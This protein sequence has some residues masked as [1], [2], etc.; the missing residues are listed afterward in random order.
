MKYGETWGTPAHALFAAMVDK[1]CNGMQS[2][3]RGIIRIGK[4]AAT[5]G[6]PSLSGIRPQI[7]LLL[8]PSIFK[9]DSG[10]VER[11]LFQSPL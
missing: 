2:R 11:L 4:A 5:R 6:L 8:R 3:S 7:R 9:K 1:D 10:L